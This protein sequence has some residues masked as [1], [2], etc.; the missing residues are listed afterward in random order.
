LYQ[1]ASPL[2]NIGGKKEMTITLEQAKNL[3]HGK[4]LHTNEGCKRWRV[5]GK[6][7]RWK[8]DPDRFSVPIKHG[9]WSYDYLENNGLEMV[10]LEKDCPNRK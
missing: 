6:V 2:G 1:S 7:K 3:T 9:V 4:I 10:H 5:N 8:R